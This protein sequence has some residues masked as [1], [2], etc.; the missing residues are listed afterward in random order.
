MNKF[1]GQYSGSAKIADLAVQVTNPDGQLETKL[2]VEI[3]F[4]E[5]YADLVKDI[6]LWLEG[7]SSVSMCV[8][9]SFEEEP[10][11]QC[12]IDNNM[13]EEEFKKLE[14][15][16]PWELEPKDIHLESPFGPATYKELDGEELDDEELDNKKL[17]W[18]GRISTAFLEQWKRDKKT[19]KAKKYGKRVVSYLLLMRISLTKWYVIGSSYCSQYQVQTE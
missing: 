6:R 11:Y 15:P 17:V 14:F 10:P 1:E 16:N 7:M 3:G 8:L 13:D 5:K 12:P 18:V 9:V 4:S 19:G 2:V